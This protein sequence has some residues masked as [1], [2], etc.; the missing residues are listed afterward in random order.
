MGRRKSSSRKC[1]D[2]NARAKRN[3]RRRIRVGRQRHFSR[4]LLS[5]PWRKNSLIRAHDQSTLVSMG[6]S[7]QNL[8]RKERRRPKTP[9]RVYVFVA[10]RRRP[11]HNV[12]GCSSSVSRAN[13]IEN[14]SLC[15]WQSG[16]SRALVFFVTV[17]QHRC[18]LG[19]AD[20]S[21]ISYA[22]C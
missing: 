14:R 7:K 18:N 12:Q 10:K 20:H 21:L 17:Y 6:R 8:D 3:S 9:H 4:G 1:M 22:S 11:V 13:R 5:T 16:R 2:V 15:F 19:G